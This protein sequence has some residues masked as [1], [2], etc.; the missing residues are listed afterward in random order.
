MTVTAWMD[1]L[2]ILFLAFG[3]LV[4]HNRSLKTMIRYFGIQ[5]FFLASLTAFNGYL[6]YH[7]TAYWVAVL[8]FIGKCLVIP[9]VL[10]YILNKTEFRKTNDSLLPSPLHTLLGG[11]VIVAS[12]MLTAQ[13]N[14]PQQQLA[15]LNV[16]LSVLLLGLMVMINSRHAIGQIIGLYLL[17]NGIYCLTIATVFEMPFIVEMGIFLD[18]LIGLIVLGT[19]VFRLQ[20]T[21]KHLDVYELRQLKG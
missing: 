8:V 6:H 1:F 14:L 11:F 16:S 2:L 7:Q 9:L 20:K 18:L 19:W 15:F 4:L 10:L 21:F 13:F 5:S 3:L 12:F 17:D